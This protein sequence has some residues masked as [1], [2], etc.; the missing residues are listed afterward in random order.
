[1]NR[2]SRKTRR[3]RRKIRKNGFSSS[4]TTG[5]PRTGTLRFLIC[6]A[7]WDAGGLQ[8]ENS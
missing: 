7:W 6:L 4:G 8:I 5:L 3:A 2:L 1:M